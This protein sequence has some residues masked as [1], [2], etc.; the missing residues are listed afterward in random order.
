MDE[1]CQPPIIRLNIDLL[2]LIFK[3]N[4]DMFADDKALETT[5][6][7]SQVCREWRGVML[8]SPSLWGHLIDL[9]ALTQRRDEWRN[10]V[11]R[12]SG[13][14]SLS[15]KSFN[16]LFILR[17]LVPRSDGSLWL[18]ED[19]SPWEIFFFS[20][21]DKKWNKIERLTIRMGSH[22]RFPTEILCSPAPQL[23]IFEVS[24]AN[25]VRI[26]EQQ[27]R[28][29]FDDKAPLLHTF[30]SRNLTFQLSASWIQNLRSVE[31]GPL[32]PISSVLDV[33]KRAPMLEDII[34]TGSFGNGQSGQIT[35]HTSSFVLGPNIRSL[36][37]GASLSACLSLL[38]SVI[39][40]HDYLLQIST[41]R[42]GLETVPLDSL[43]HYTENHFHVHAPTKITLDISKKFQFVTR[44]SKGPQFV[45]KVLCS[46]AAGR[47]GPLGILPA[48]Q[49]P[50]CRF[51]TELDLTSDQVLR[52]EGKLP[53]SAFLSL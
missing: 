21:I 13:E 48:L 7:S 26:E 2:L 17:S 42:F 5:R 36:Q 33:L 20:L 28:S 4:A 22:I 3:M 51:V 14:S 35:P 27:G 16:A 12:R 43:S 45:L 8:E 1:T 15:I 47:E 34:Y 10:E 23:Q 29:I 50:V 19:I 37:I 18:A 11:L 30:H 31:M 52:E 40:T 41:S 25:S 38:G 39:P 49:I 44:N 46:D 53:V 6:F 9:D 24:T 32:F